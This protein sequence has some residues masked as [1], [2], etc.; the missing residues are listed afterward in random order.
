MYSLQRRERAELIHGYGTDNACATA[1][2]HYQRG[3]EKKEARV[4]G[5][6]G[7]GRTASWQAQPKPTPR[8]LLAALFHGEGEKH[9]TRAFRV[10]P[11]GSCIPHEIR[12]LMGGAE[13]NHQGAKRG[14]KAP[15]F[16]HVAVMGEG[17]KSASTI[18]A[19]KSLACWREWG[20]GR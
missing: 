12:M 6:G 17:Q 1:R 14:E 15:H 7:K 16:S 2:S 4:W 19:G 10:P 9:G 18:M 11:G 3:R 20:P 5:G 13:G 8:H